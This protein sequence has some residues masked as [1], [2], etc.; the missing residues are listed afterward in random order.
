MVF[1][2]LVMFDT[3][4]KQQAMWLA[5]VAMEPFQTLNVSI[6]SSIQNILSKANFVK[7][8]A[9]DED[10]SN[11][12]VRYIELRTLNGRGL[13]TMPLDEIDDYADM[14]GNQFLP[15]VNTAFEVDDD[16]NRQDL[17]IQ[18]I[19]DD[20]FNDQ[21][22]PTFDA[23]SND[24]QND[25][26]ADH[27]EHDA[28]IVQLDD[29]SEHEMSVGTESMNHASRDH[30]RHAMYTQTRHDAIREAAGR[31]YDQNVESIQQQ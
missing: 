14:Y 22:L 16:G 30:T 11:D 29:Q 31:R 3:L 15:S 12:H 20:D 7:D 27:S 24:V 25:R 2:L 17:N 13:T 28:H 5:K 9:D 4:M 6:I 1:Q 23:D 26:R 10:P 19:F 21:F 8:E 18:D